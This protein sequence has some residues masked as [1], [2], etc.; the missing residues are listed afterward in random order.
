MTA[1]AEVRKQVIREIS[2]NS[3]QF[4]P[5]NSLQPYYTCYW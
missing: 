4:I 2:G 1:E 3:G 5:E